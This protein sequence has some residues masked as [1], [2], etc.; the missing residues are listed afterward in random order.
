MLD[1]DRRLLM[2]PL[3]PETQRRRFR[4]VPQ[5]ARRRAPLGHKRFEPENPVPS[6]LLQAIRLSRLPGACSLGQDRGRGRSTSA[7]RLAAR[8][9]GRKLSRRASAA[10]ERRRIDPDAGAHG[11]GD[12]DALDEGALGPGRPRLL[13]RIGERLD[14]GDQR[15]LSKLALPT[16]AWTIPAFSTRNSTAPPLASS[17]ALATSMVT[18]PTFGFGIRPRGPEHLTETADE[19]HHVGRGDAAVEIDLAAL[20]LLDQILGPDDVGAGLLGLLGLGAAWRTPRRAATRPVPFGSETT[21]RTIW[22]A[23]RGST[24]RFMAISTVS[25]NFALARSLTIFTASSSG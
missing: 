13:D 25:S 24:P 17:T 2:P 3:R 15:L 12:G 18:V 10:L 20:D 6:R 16:P 9:P 23:W 14:V 22:S 21:P 8:L 4:P 19:R 11:R 7:A 5:P 1:W